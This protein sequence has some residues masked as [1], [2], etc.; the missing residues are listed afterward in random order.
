M[1]S[2]VYAI[3]TIIEFINN[4]NEIVFNEGILIVYDEENITSKR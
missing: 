3:M 1:D 4:K 2:I